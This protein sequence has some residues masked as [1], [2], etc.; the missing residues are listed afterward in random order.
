MWSY[1]NEFKCKWNDIKEM[2]V[3]IIVIIAERGGIF[4]FAFDEIIKDFVLV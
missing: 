4:N 2:A 1:L 3:L